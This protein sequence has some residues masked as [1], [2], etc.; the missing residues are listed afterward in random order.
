MA[1]HYFSLFQGEKKALECA[2]FLQY[3]FKN[4]AIFWNNIAIFCNNIAIMYYFSLFQGEKKASEDDD[5]EEEEEP[6]DMKFPTG[7]NANWKKILIYI[8]SF[9]LMAPMYITLPD[10]RDKSSKS[11]THTSWQVQL[12]GKKR[13]TNSDFKICYVDVYVIQNCKKLKN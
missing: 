10:T 9:P 6:I 13:S 8:A 2:I 1:M 3:Q 12:R 11:P 7:E 5:D 4:I